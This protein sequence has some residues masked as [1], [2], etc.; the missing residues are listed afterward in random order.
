MIEAAGG[1]GLK[2]VNNFN[3]KAANRANQLFEEVQNQ[4]C[5]VQS[6]QSISLLH[7]WPGS[8]FL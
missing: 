7:Q 3:L 4:L 2:P 5:M 6:P 1:V 8:A